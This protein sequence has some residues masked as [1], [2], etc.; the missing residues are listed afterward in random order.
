[1]VTVEKAQ[2][3]TRVT[4]EDRRLWSSP[5]ARVMAALESGDE[6]DPRDVQALADLLLVDTVMM[7]CGS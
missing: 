6:A 1:M 4:D 7:G 3:T 5:V 2:C